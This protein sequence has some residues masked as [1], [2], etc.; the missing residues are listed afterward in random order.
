MMESAMRIVTGS[1]LVIFVLP[2]AL[3]VAMLVLL[4]VGRRSGLKRRQHD[5]GG[6]DEGFGALEASILGLLGLLLAFTF[7]GAV[8]RFDRRRELIVQEAISI[9]DAWARIDTLPPETQPAIRDGLRRYVESRLK[10]YRLLPDVGAAAAEL[11]RSITIQDEIW[12]GAVAACA[13][14]EG[15]RVTMIVLPAFDDAFDMTTMRAAATMDH[16]PVVIYVLLIA[17]ALGSA[18]IAGHGMSGATRRP[19]TFMIGFAATT[20]IAVYTIVDI[21]YPR[22]GFVRVDAFDQFLEDV[23]RSMK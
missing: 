17:L 18:V 21:E 7:S 14:P 11:Q 19:W 2:V 5:P 4:E 8:E 23:L 15:Q 3:L 10:A 12:A 22:V 13:K 20:A 1:T 16:P 6:S 9:G